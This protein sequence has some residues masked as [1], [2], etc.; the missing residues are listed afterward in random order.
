MLM[1]GLRSDLSDPT[2]DEYPE[3][4]GKQNLMTQWKNMREIY[5]A[6]ERGAKYIDL[7][8]REQHCK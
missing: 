7:D 3:L 4:S 2:V 8:G 6:N 5:C 1:D